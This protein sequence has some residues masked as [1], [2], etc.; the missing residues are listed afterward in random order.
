MRCYSSHREKGFAFYEYCTWR[1]SPTKTCVYVCGQPTD[2]YAMRPTLP[3][4]GPRKPD[5]GVNNAH[6]SKNM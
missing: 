4:S 2:H 1:E 5:I 6:I 3:K